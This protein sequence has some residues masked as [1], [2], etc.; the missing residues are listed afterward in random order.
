MKRLSIAAICLALSAG[1]VDRTFVYKPSSPVAGRSKLPAKVAVIPFVDGT[2]DFTRRG[3][4]VSREVHKVNLARFTSGSGGLIDPVPPEAWSK[5]LADEMAA[6]GRFEAVRFLYARSELTDEDYVVEGTL[7]K[8]I[9]DF[10]TSGDPHEFGLALRA[11]RVQDNA[12]AWGQDLR[13]APGNSGGIAA[14]CPTK[15]CLANLYHGVVNRAM[16]EMFSE[17]GESLA[18]ALA[19]LAGDG[20]RGGAPPSGGSSVPAAPGS[21]ESEI[22]RILKAN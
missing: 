22:E 15:Q 21:I 1:C 4:L 6:S 7:E 11:L 18:A 13:K 5:A 12:T 10:G 17:A 16:Q 14:R 2:E 19:P 3:G 8:A 9:L 20:A